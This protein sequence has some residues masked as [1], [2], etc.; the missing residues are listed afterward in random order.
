MATKETPSDIIAEQ[1]VLGSML[2]S[3]YALQKACDA[4]TEESFHYPKHS[5]IFSVVKEYTF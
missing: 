4:L 3:N 5:K 1:S 2:L